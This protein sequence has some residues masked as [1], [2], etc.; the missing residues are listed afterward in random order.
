MNI[1]PSDNTITPQL[2][3]VIYS[4]DASGVLLNSL[5]KLIF[6]TPIKA[7]NGDII[8]TNGSGDTR[9]I[10]INDSTQITINTNVI[11]IKPK[12]NF[13]P[14]SHYTFTIAAGVIADSVGNAFAGINPH[15]PVSFATQDVI[16]SRYTKQDT[17]FVN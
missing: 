2:T 8:M 15:N 5:S 6:N 12:D 1:L 7:I 11:I 14:N 4:N 17:N 3:D 16:W 10:S 13:I 9:I